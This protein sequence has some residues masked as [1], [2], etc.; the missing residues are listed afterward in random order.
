MDVELGQDVKESA[1][2]IILCIR[3][4]GGVINNSIVIGILNGILHDTDSNLL[5]ENS[6]P[7]QI[8]SPIARCLLMR[9]QYV[10][11]KGTTKAKSHAIR[12]S[13]VADSLFE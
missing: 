3:E 4:A 2:K 8:D 12:L 13:F 9:M 6:G 7:I 11:R 1:K 5:A 10:K